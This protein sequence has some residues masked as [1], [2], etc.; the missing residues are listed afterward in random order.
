[1][2]STARQLKLIHDTFVPNQIDRT[3]CAISSSVKH[4][5][6]TLFNT[7]RAEIRRWQSIR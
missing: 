1:M 4:K 5:S 2:K 7:F 6:K 3:C